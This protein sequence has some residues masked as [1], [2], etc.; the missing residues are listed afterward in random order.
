M[1]NQMQKTDIIIIGAGVVGLSIATALSRKSRNIIVLEKEKAFGQGPSSR[2]SEIIHSGI[3]YKKNSLKAKLCV[4]GKELLYEFC[5]QQEI[6]HKRLGK[7][8]VATDNDEAG[9]LEKLFERGRDNGVEDLQL[10][11][12]TELKKIE[13]QVKAVSAISAPSTGIV[14]THQ[15][16]KK[17]HYISESRGVVFAYNCE[18]IDITEKKEC[19]EVFIRDADGENINLF[20]KTLI[21]SA[22]LYSD[23]MAEM[24]GIDIKKHNC[25]LHY[26]KGEYFRLNQSKAR[27]IKHLIYPTPDS[28]SLGIHTVADLQGQMKLGPNAF[29]VDEIDYDVD[30]NHK[31]EFYM[32]AKRYLPFLECGDLTPDMAGIRAK[33]QAPGEPERDFIISDEKEKGF[34]GLIDLIGIESPGLTA[35]LAIAKYVGSML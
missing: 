8:I 4:E 13:P 19:Y 10:L 28:T 18:V 11:D 26:S 16:M 34:P 9:E 22:G 15:F 24:A 3:Y 20:T 23:E 6:P 7:L 31:E 21:N 25:E 2:N 14:D 5:Q 27:L 32:S 30:V 33:L 12:K 1:C 35:S 29:Y 17:L